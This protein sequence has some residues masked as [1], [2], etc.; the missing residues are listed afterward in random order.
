MIIGHVG[1]RKGSK[2]VTGK[3]FRSMLGKPLID[4]SLDQLLQHPR[5]CHAVVSTD[6]PRI[7]RHAVS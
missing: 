1:A 3:N 2:G 7:H 6:D 5:V 4:W